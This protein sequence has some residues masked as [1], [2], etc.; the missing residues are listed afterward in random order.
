MP[1]NFDR[2]FTELE[3]ELMQI[4]WNLQECSIRG[5]FDALPDDRELAYTTVATMVK[6][7]EKKGAISCQKKDR[8]ITV[9]PKIDRT[10]YEETSLK[11]LNEKVFKGDASTM[12]TRLLDVEDLSIDELKEIKKLLN[13]RLRS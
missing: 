6:I 7:L 4:V 5:I 10:T 9:K 8:T 11:Y 1:K 13:E 12:V 2:Q 3:L